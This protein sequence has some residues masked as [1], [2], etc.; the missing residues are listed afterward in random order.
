MTN[1]HELSESIA[2]AELRNYFIDFLIQYCNSTDDRNVQNILSELLELSDRQWHTYEMLDSEIKKQ[3]TKYI[4]TIID[5]EDEEIMDCVLCIIPR[6]G[7]GDLFGYILENKKSIKNLAVLKNI[8]E[9]ID[10]YGQ[11]VEYPYSGM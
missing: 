8:N 11:D 2:S 7:L 5:F 3:L 10:E 1:F 9:A 4:K 6:L